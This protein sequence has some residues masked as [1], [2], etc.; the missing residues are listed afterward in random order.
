MNQLIDQL[1]RRTLVSNYQAT[2]PYLKNR[3]ATD[4]S[5]KD[6]GGA[7]LAIAMDCPA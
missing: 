5:L 2:N 4:S 6:C 1:G 3:G 7:V